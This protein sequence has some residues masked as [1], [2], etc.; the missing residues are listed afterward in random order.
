MSAK[1]GPAY[2]C[3]EVYER[4]GMCGGSVWF[5][6]RGAINLLQ[7]KGLTAATFRK[8]YEENIPEQW[9]G[10]SDM[11]SSCFM[12]K[13]GIPMLTYSPIH[14]KAISFDSSFHGPNTTKEEL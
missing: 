12:Y 8:K 9:K 14:N 11:Y 10:A 13:L 6:S 2:V 5:P 3:K 4:G 7:T 1:R